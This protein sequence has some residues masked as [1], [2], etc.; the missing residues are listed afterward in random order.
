M[1]SCGDFEHACDYTY[2]KLSPVGA[3]HVANLGTDHV[4]DR[5]VVAETTAHGWHLVHRIESH[6]LGLNSQIFFWFFFDFFKYIFVTFLHGET[7]LTLMQVV[8]QVTV[9]CQVCSRFYTS[10]Q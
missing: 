5:H 9:Q 10:V 6:V 4:K 2:G 7:E 3:D 1:V 8:L